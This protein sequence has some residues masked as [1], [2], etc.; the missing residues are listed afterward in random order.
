M[1]AKK[2]AKAKHIHVP[3]Q[4]L[5]ACAVLF[6]VLVVFVAPR[7]LHRYTTAVET[8]LPKKTSILQLDSFKWG[9]VSEKKAMTPA[10]QNNKYI[11]ITASMR[12]S[13][14]AG[15]IWLA[16]ALQSYVIDSNGAHHGIELVELDNPLSGGQYNAQTEVSGQLAYMVPASDKNVQWCYVLSDKTGKEAKICQPLVDSNKVTD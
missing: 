15:S 7:V 10:I 14:D 1:P 9:E 13:A 11:S 16:P 5:L 6:L 3:I 2:K 8:K 12:T 4:A